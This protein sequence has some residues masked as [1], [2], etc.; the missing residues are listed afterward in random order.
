MLM[1][2]PNGT[3]ID[4]SLPE[5]T[6]MTS[7]I[8]DNMSQLSLEGKCW[9]DERRPNT[10]SSSYVSMEMVDPRLRD[11]PMVANRLQAAK[12]I[13]IIRKP[14]FPDVVSF[15]KRKICSWLRHYLQNGSEVVWFSYFVKW[16]GFTHEDN[17]WEKRV[18]V[19]AEKFDSKYAYYG[20]N[21]IRVNLL[22]KSIL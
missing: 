12:E 10:P 1:R 5:P 17:A 16:D 22:E 18:N 21:K 9:A 8:H 19:M 20:G 3:K 13:V 14:P 6:L 4:L 15:F 11:D 7:P 2:I